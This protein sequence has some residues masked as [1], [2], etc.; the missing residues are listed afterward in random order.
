MYWGSNR[1]N[2]A[3]AGLVKQ[4]HSQLAD[5]NKQIEA[6]RQAQSNMTSIDDQ[7]Y[8]RLG[9]GAN[10]YGIQKAA[11]TTLRDN[12]GNLQERF[13]ETL[14]PS[15]QKLKDQYD[16]EGDTNWANL[17]RQQLGNQLSEASDQARLRNNT[18]LATSQDRLAMRGGLRGGAGERMM[19]GNQRNLMSQ[20]Q[21]LGAENR[22]GNLKV[23]IA[24][25]DMKNKMLGQLGQAGQEISNRNISRLQGDIQNQNKFDAGRYS[26]DMAAYGAKQTAQAQ[27][28][29]SSCFAACTMVKMQ[30]GSF[31]FISDI[32]LGDV[33]FEGGKV[34]TKLES[35]SDNLYL[36]GN[37][38]VTG[39][40]AVLEDG[41]WKRVENSDKAE[42]LD[43]IDTKVFN[44]S[45][46]NHMICTQNTIFA[47]FDETMYGSHLTDED[48]LRVLNG[49]DAKELLP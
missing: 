32:Q 2:Y 25:Q 11:Y 36:Y 34:Y 35:I 16:V 8:Q 41:S 28:K 22:A 1:N 42:M 39:G 5:L 43:K 23:S 15:L 47:D 18:A 26:D 37:T 4:Q 33:L 6:M 46:E 19:M 14:D 40:H 48:S 49:A 45:T 29:S 12:D 44:L 20:L 10:Q 38:I 21:G 9:G 30:D 24:D 13:K 3:D 27:R 17:Q 7:G 31:K